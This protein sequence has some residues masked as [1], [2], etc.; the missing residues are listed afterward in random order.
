ML[1][2]LSY[3]REEP[4]AGAPN[5]APAS[6]PPIMTDPGHNA[7]RAPKI[8]VV[9]SVGP[10]PHRRARGLRARAAVSADQ[11]TASDAHVT[12]GHQVE[13]GTDGALGAHDPLNPPGASI[14][15]GEFR[16][17]VTPTQKE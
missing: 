12:F 4:G 14:V 17:L 11:P 2:Q 10:Q 8:A 3:S 1:Y 7:S 15:P 6:E 16:A 9:G 13:L 5:A